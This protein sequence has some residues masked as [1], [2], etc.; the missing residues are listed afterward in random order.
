VN[1]LPLVLALEHGLLDP[2]RRLLVRSKSRAKRFSM[3]TR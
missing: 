3:P 1:E 2:R